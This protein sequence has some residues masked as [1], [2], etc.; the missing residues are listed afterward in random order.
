MKYKNLLLLILVLLLP[1]ISHAID[2]STSYT[3]A[4]S[5][6]ADYLGQI[7]KNLAGQESVALARSQLLPQI[8][9][10]GGYSENYLGAPGSSVYYHQP[11]INGQ[12][13]QVIFDW[14]KYSQ[15]TKGKYGTQ[16]AD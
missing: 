11:T 14:S 13:S 2:L 12:L 7:A 10:T 5:Y 8:S 16:V 6:N 15:Y 3:N 9:A 1:L 4:L